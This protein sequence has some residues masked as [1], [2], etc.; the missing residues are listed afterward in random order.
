MPQ[1][2]FNNGELQDSEFEKW[3]NDI[4]EKLSKH[5]KAIIAVDNSTNQKAD[6]NLLREKKATIAERILQKIKLKEILIEG[7]STAYSIIQKT[8][9]QSFIPT[10]ELQQGIVRMQVEGINDLHLTIKP[11]SYQWPPE[12]NFN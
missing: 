5:N 6:P 12:W 11:G 9:W 2:I 7:G 10:E 3:Q 1:N 8:G 4:L